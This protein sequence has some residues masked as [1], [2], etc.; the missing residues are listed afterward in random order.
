MQRF[1]LGLILTIF[2]FSSVILQ[3]QTDS[4]K[5]DDLITR[6]QEYGLFNGSA[7]VVKNG[8]VIFKKGYGYANF[9]WKVQNAPDTKFRI[10]SISKQFTATLIMQ[11]V[12]EGK[13]KLDGKITDYLPEYRKDPGDSVTI[14]QLL[15]HTSGIKSYTSI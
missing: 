7:L 1:K 4:E 9:E 8:K 11:L 5:I 12:E 14:H 13:I 6:Y 15:N 10:G 2:F 3:S